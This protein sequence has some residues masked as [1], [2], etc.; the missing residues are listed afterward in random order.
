MFWNRKKR[1]PTKPRVVIIESACPL[2]FEE[3]C[4]KLLDDGYVI[5]DYQICLY[6]KGIHTKDITGKEINANI[7]RSAIMVLK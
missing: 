7:W 3:A 4:G 5:Q 1:N 6:D 2:Q